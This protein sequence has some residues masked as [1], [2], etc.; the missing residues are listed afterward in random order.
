MYIFN[1]CTCR[2]M[3]E[4]IGDVVSVNSDRG[5]VAKMHESWRLG[6]RYG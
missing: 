4:C 2:W 5:E 3:F 6:E 1:A